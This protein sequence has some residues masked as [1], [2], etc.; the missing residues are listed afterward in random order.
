MTARPE[1]GLRVL[2]FT[3]LFPNAVQPDFGGFV[4]RRMEAWAEHHGA[5]WAVVAPVPFFPR[6]PWRTKWDGFSRVPRAEKRGRWTV[7][8]PRY[9]MLPGLGGFFQGASMARGARSA[10]ERLWREE[11]PFDLIDAHFV[12]PDGYAAVKLARRLGVPAVVS[13]RGTDVNL[14]PELRGIGPKV[15][16]TLRN[17]DAL[18]AVSRGLLDRMVALGADP[19]RCHLVPNGVDL[20]RFAPTE[21]ADGGRPRLLT[22]C[23]LVAG[24]GVDTVIRALAGLG[25]DA[26]LWVAGDGPERPRLER[27]AR[28][29]GVAERV[30]FLGR[31]PHTEMP[32]LYARAR[33]FCLASRAEGCPN[34][35]LEALA[36]GVPVVAT[37]VGGIPEWVEDGRNGFLVPTG[38]TDALK[39]ALARALARDWDAQTIREAVAGRSWSHVA[40]AVDGVF[41]EARRGHP[42]TRV[43]ASA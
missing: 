16:W 2:T 26:E 23:N 17:A 11:G 30:R 18:I 41:R 10:V 24:K 8:H 27:L 20:E 37:A 13:A 9:F 22:V 5:R 34:V 21:A 12:Y 38:D 4:A 6:L 43:G 3:S 15:R 19:E 42:E 33:V 25:A 28:D 31:V 32:G 14:Y 36:S 35:V 1:G 40:E 29:L 39:A 7:V